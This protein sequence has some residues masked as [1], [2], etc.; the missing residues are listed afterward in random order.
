MLREY[1]WSDDHSFLLPN[2]VLCLCRQPFVKVGN[3]KEI[4]GSTIG[5]W[6]TILTAS[7]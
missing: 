1:C 3:S 6:D 2:S 5:D 7:K 4:P